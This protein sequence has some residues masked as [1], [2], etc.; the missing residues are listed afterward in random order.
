MDFS[1]PI[2]WNPDSPSGARSKHLKNL[3]LGAT[4]NSLRTTMEGLRL[5]ML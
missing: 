3:Q 4:R 1:G 5:L 2:G